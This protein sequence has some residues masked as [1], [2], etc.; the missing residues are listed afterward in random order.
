MDIL[1]SELIVDK[2]M[3]IFSKLIFFIIKS[4]LT[5][6]PKL[7][8]LFSVLIVHLMKLATI[9]FS[10]GKFNRS[11]AE[12]QLIVFINTNAV[13]RDIVILFVTGLI[14]ILPFFLVFFYLNLNTL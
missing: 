8:T 10:N 5:L 4:T 12:S 1:K 11:S 14:F 2:P 7:N 3:S 6:S 9:K 13:I